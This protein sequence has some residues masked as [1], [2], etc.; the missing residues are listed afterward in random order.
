MVL[1]ALARMA[2]RQFSLSDFARGS[3]GRPFIA[4]APSFSITHCQGLVAAAVL[5]EGSIGLDAEL[6][7]R[8]TVRVLRKICDADEMQMAQ[9]TSATRVWVAKEAGIKCLGLSAFMAG[10]VRLWPNYLAVHNQVLFLRRILLAPE[11]EVAIASSQPIADNQILLNSPLP[12][13]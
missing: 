11:Y 8:P 7:E 1:D 6:A 4:G 3:H 13:L 10:H 12:A 5:R 9:S 2:G